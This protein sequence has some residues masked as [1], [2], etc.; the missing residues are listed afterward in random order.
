MKFKNSKNQDV[1]KFLEG[2]GQFRHHLKIKSITE[3]KEKK[4]PKKYREENS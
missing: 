4:C 1:Q 3:V 2:K